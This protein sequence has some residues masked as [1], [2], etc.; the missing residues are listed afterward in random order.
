MKKFLSVLLKIAIS[1]LLFWWLSRNVNGRELLKFFQSIPPGVILAVLGLGFLNVA[2]QGIR[3]FYSVRQL[4]PPFTFKQALISH[5]A[6]FMFRLMLPGSIGEVGKAFLLPGTTKQRIYTFMLDS[7]FATG[8]LFFFFGISTWLLYPRMWYMLG[9]CVIFVV[10]FWVYRL[11]KKNTDFKNYVPEH[12]PYLKILVFNVG[13]TML[14][15]I[16][17]I[18]QYWLMLKPYGIAWLDQA[19]ACFFIL[20]VASVPVSFAGLGFRENA[21]HIVMQPFGVP[22]EVAVGAALFAFCANVILPA[23]AGVILLNFFSE[24]KYHDIRN[25]IKRGEKKKTQSAGEN[26]E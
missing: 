23:L 21:A 14:T 24:I 25:F 9:F 5:Y 20:G 15:Y 18:S 17:F 22:A 10:L 16:A 11:L 13:V 19:K 1:A 2:G 8:T 12:V 4:M 6:G 3:Y 7:F 26:E